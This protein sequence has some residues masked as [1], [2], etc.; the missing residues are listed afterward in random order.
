MQIKTILI[1]LLLLSLS[2]VTAFGS[3]IINSQT[4]ALII[5]KADPVSVETGQYYKKL[6]NIPEQN[7]IYISIK[8]PGSSITPDIFNKIYQQVQLQ[9]G[10]NIQA[11]ALAW[12]KP[13]KAGCMSITSAFSLGY[14]KQYCAT[15]CKTTKSLDY[16]NSNSRQPFND[17]K[18]RPSMMLAGSNIESIKKTLNKGVQADYSRPKGTAY[19]LNTSDKER[20]VR[21]VIYPQIIKQLSSIINIEIIRKNYIA[22]KEDVMFYFTGNTYVGSLSSN[23]FIAG[24]AA[25][26]LTSTGGV[27][28]GKHQMS[29]LKWLDAGATASY[30]TV[31]EPCNFLAKFPNPGT[32]M[33]HYLNGNTIL[34]AYWKSVAMPGQGVFVGE[35]LSSPYKDCRIKIN[36]QGVFSFFQSQPDNYILRSSARC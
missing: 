20:N 6:R 22:D 14:D 5:N 17:Y 7:I 16:Y 33:S 8:N 25:D 13:Y 2:S 18:I 3:E 11:Y 29:I 4:L 21:S 34:E 12:S 27:L 19:L 10:K 24:A 1:I 36:A 26:H 35:P 23:N 15:E 30:G 9:T 32:L 28:F 31:L